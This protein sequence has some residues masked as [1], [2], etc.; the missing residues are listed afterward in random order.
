MDITKLRYFYAA[1]ETQHITKASEAIHVAQPALTHAIKSLESELG[2]PLFTKSGRN[3]VLTE[4]GLFLKRKLD[5]ILPELDEIPEDIAHLKKQVRRTIRLNILAASAFMIETIVKYRESHPDVI[6]DLEQNELKDGCDIKIYTDGIRQ[7]GSDRCLK[8]FVKEE[9]IYLAVPIHSEYAA[10]DQID[11]SAVRDERFVMLS[12]SRPFRAICDRL[13]I[14]AG[15]YPKTLFES[16]SP[17]AVQNII[18][19]GSGIA[20][21]PEFSW[22]KLRSG[23][24]KLLPIVHPDD[25]RR[26]LI[27]E[28]CQKNPPSDCAE[29]FYDFLIGEL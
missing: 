7:S 11:L 18:G 15:F 2:V 19:T 5:R 8:R 12:G 10:L 26:D 21:W 25:C 17:V 1:A 29:D 27:I 16:D 14:R 28:L 4:Y 22:G 6:I 23:K 3:V 24:V 9:Q 13:C 20:F